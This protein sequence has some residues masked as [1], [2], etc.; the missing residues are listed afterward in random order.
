MS[1]PRRENTGWDNGWNDAIDEGEGFEEHLLSQDGEYVN[2]RGYHVHQ[3]DY[4][5]TGKGE[6]SDHYLR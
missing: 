4:P 2:Q 6:P 3:Y 1:D 5:H